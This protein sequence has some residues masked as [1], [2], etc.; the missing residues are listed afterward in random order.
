MTFADIDRNFPLIEAATRLF[1]GNF[2]LPYSTKPQGHIETDIASASSVAGLMLLR[3]TGLDLTQAPPGA[4]LVFEGIYEPQNQMLRFLVACAY[5]LGI[6]HESGWNTPV[7]PDHKPLFE[8][9]EMT[10]KLEGPLYQACA[11]SGISKDYSAHV[12]ALTALKLV[13][14]GDKVKLIDI[15][16][17]KS[18]ISY[19]V[20]AGSRTIPYPFVADLTTDKPAAPQVDQV[21]GGHADEA[22]TYYIRAIGRKA[23]GDNDGAIA[24]YTEAIRLNP[25]FA[26]A[27]YNRG[28]TW[29]AKEDIDKAI[30]DYSEAIRLNPQLANAYYSRSV[31]HT[32]KGNVD[33]AIADSSE[34]IRLNPQLAA[35]YL[36]RGAGYKAK[37][38]Y[39][40]AIA[41]FSEYLR[42]NPQSDVAYFGR[43]IVRKAQGDIAGAIADYT[44]A[45]RI[46]PKYVG[47]YLN[48]GIAHDANGNK[49]AACADY[50][51]LLKS[52]PNHAQAKML[53]EYIAKN[54]G[55]RWPFSR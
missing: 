46:N 20:V 38:N 23:Q 11:Q 36:N 1:L 53:R 45:L 48:R 14:A 35:A 39:D 34:V 29:K 8:T 22:I 49:K 31:A 7:P 13:V 55:W 50:K 42:L 5:N 3:A 15:N 4:A 47:V 18:L 2:G 52:E 33:G 32:T 44:E 37:G 26:D 41:D 24:D 25:Q 40:A 21:T 27:Y 10:Q 9:L 17:G 28:L 51:Q 16:V 30:A 19:Y 12:A 54:D 6:E 43:A